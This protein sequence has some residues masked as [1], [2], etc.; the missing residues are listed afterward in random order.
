[1]TLS[2]LVLP[3]LHKRLVFKVE[4]LNNYCRNLKCHDKLPYYI[5]KREK[6]KEELERKPL[7]KTW[8]NDVIFDNYQIK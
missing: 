5:I 4:K 2:C 6:G 3:I 7:L 8:E 1:M